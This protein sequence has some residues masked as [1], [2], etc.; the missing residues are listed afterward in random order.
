MNI[1]IVVSDLHCG[2]QLGL[3]PPEGMKLDE[4]GRYEPSEFQRIMWTYWL[5]F[6]N[7]WVPTVTTGEPYNIVLNGDIIDGVHHHSTHQISHNIKDQETLAYAIMEPIVA[8]CPGNYYQIRGTGVHDGEAGVSAERVARQLGAVPNKIG[9]HARY[10]LWK[11]LGPDKHSLIHYLHHI[12]TTG[13]SAYEATAV[14]KELAEAFVEA[15]R[16]EDRAPNAIVR[17][18]RHRNIK[19][20]APSAHGRAFCVVTPAW[21]GKTPFTHRIP[22]A[23]QSQPQ[24]G[25]IMLRVSDEGELYER[26][27]VK[28]LDRPEPE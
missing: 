26:S 27:Y 25:G 17:S 6:W 19:T 9:Q 10:E 14:Y 5:E 24:F 20:E 18:H 11:Y 7:E 13:S 8:A 22:G 1:D 23:R 4:G 15:G 28:H 3:C 16:W 2:C 21:Q 12:G